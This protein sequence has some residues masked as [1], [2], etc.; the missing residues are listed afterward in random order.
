[1]AQGSNKVGTKVKVETRLRVL[2]WAVSEYAHAFG[3]DKDCLETIEKGIYERQIIE[4]ITFEYFHG[5]EFVGRI[6]LKIDWA[7]HEMLVNDENGKMIQIR[8]DQSIL[9]QLD[10]ASQV[11]QDHVARLR[12]ECKVS[13][14]ETYY[15]Y[16]EEYTSDDSKHE[17]AQK[18]LGHTSAKDRVQTEPTVKFKTIHRLVM[19]KLKE[20]EVTV[21]S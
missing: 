13:E 19:G 12:K 14:I 15:R 6:T 18:F 3:A 20:L 10:E 9:K 4:Q 21:E 17:E 7:C 2:T 16:R 1:M 5:K 8:K 11:I